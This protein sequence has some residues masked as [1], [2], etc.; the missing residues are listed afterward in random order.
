M[1][2]GSHGTRKMSKISP[3]DTFDKTSRHSVVDLTSARVMIMN[4]FL[5]KKQHQ[6]RVF[7]TMQVLK[8][9]LLRLSLQIYSKRL[10]PTDKHISK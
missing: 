6:I 3:V 5:E 9:K 7:E 10:N 4:K 2:L 1:L 8:K